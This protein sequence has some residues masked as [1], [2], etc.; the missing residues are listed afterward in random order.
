VNERYYH[1]ASPPTHNPW[2]TKSQ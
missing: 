2:P 1:D